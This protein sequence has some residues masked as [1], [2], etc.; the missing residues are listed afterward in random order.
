M[1]YKSAK[2]LYIKIFKEM[3]TVNVIDLNGTWT[4]NNL[5]N[6]TRFHDMPVTIPGSIVTGAL[7]NN[8]I[9][10]PCY[11][12]N[13]DAIQ[14]LFND[15]YS[16]SRTFTLETEVLMSEQILLNCEGLD[17]LATIFINHTNVLET[18]NMFRRYKFDIKPYVE[19]GENIIEIQ[20]YSPVQ[21]LK[22]IKLQGENGLAYLRKA[23]CMFGWDWG[24]K[25]PD[26]GIWKSIA[27]EYGDYM[28][29]PPFLFTQ[30][31]HTQ[32]VEL[33]VRSKKAIDEATSLTCTLYDP[34][35]Q[36]IESITINNSHTFKH[37]FIIENPQLWWPIGYGEQPLYT[38]DVELY[39]GNQSIDH[40][41]Y[42]IGLRTVKLN[43][44]NDGDASKFEF[45]INDTPVFIKGTNMIIEDAILTQSR[46]YSLT[47]QIKD[48]VRANI[49]C[50][51]VWEAP[52]TR[53]TF[54]LIC[55]IN[56]VF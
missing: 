53:Q 38:V 5:T 25:L 1:N 8:L 47:A 36:A 23:Q 43:R 6:T 13:E 37:T 15:H 10:H 4:L 19:L 46:R 49:N 32:T 29:I 45:I 50:I 39:T 35:N 26:F 14:Y 16:F 42:S 7:E 3:D 21:Y 30:T 17:T 51:R 34:N 56:T 22:E 54:S 31:H 18:D 41:S 27:I 11:G 44:D 20:F 52:T 33:N 2:L 28:N 55:A 40:T 9:N 48:C 24:I 12:N